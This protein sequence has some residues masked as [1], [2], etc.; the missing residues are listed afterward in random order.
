MEKEPIRYSEEVIEYTKKLRDVSF[1]EDDLFKIQQDVDYSEGEGAQWYPKSESPI[2]TELVD[3]DKLPPVAER[4]GM[5]PVILKGVDSIGEYGG[6]WFQ[7][8]GSQNEISLI[9]NFFS[10][11]TLV[12]WSPLGYPIV[13]HV[14]KGWESTP[15]KREWTFYLREGMKW[16]DGHPFSADDILYRW[17]KETAPELQRGCSA[18]LDENRWKD[19]GSYQNR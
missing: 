17:Y 9:G 10:G 11:S 13:P 15:D 2:L 1:T 4:V 3:E 14:A 12:R 5:E 7:V 18:R 6:T 8:R 19:R 16:S